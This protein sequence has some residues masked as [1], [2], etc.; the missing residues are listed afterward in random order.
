MLINDPMILVAFFFIYLI[1]GIG[2][3][4]LIGGFDRPQL[5]LARLAGR[6]RNG[7]LKPR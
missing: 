5:Q 6:R 1:A 4:A 3:L 7:D 2:I